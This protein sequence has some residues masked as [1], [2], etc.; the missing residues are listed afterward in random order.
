MGAVPIVRD[1]TPCA[2]SAVAP[3]RS[4][5]ARPSLVV[6]TDAPRAPEPA[7]NRPTSRGAARRG[8][9]LSRR[10]RV[11]H[12]LAGVDRHLI[13][14]VSSAPCTRSDGEARRVVVAASRGCPQLPQPSRRLGAPS[15]ISQTC[16]V[17]R[18]S[19]WLIVQP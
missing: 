12:S 13:R 10:R 5:T 8:P 17:S 2:A 9:P 4:L 11:E 18:S 6:S 15:S 19:H 16:E 1:P 7:R 3:A 14:A